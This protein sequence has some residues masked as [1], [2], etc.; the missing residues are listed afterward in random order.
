MEP[1]LPSLSTRFS[2]YLI[3]I[4]EDCPKLEPVCTVDAPEIENCVGLGGYFVFGWLHYS[5][6]EPKHYIKVMRFAS[7][8]RKFSEH[9]IM[10]VEWETGKRPVS[11]KIASHIKLLTPYRRKHSYGLRIADSQITVVASSTELI[12]A[13]TATPLI[14]VSSQC[15]PIAVMPLWR[16]SCAHLNPWAVYLIPSLPAVDTPSIIIFYGNRCLFLAPSF[17]ADPPDLHSTYFSTYTYPRS[18]KRPI[19]LGPHRAFWDLGGGRVGIRTL[20]TPL[21]P[22]FHEHGSWHTSGVNTPEADLA[23]DV[24]PLVYAENQNHD[25]RV[26]RAAWDEESGKLALVPRPDYERGESMTVFL[27]D[28]MT[29]Y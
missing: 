13:Y 15:E 27:V 10:A 26:E 3:N 2:V 22:A 5:D 23:H 29:A 16:F 9:C 19:L 7:C 12:A 4:S 24:R 11:P 25:R 20:P 6:S 8:Y 18:L 14:P 28:M 21:L 1:L 17:D